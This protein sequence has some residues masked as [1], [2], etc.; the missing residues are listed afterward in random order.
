[1][2]SGRWIWRALAPAAGPASV[3]PL[4][5]PMGALLL[6]EGLLPIPPP[7]SWLLHLMG[8]PAGLFLGVWWLYLG[9]AS[10]PPWPP[11]LA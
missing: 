6:R 1:M 9:G 11:R 5:A 3:Y 4:A 8:C 10:V 2:T 7:P